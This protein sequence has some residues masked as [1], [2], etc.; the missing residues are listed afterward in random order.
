MINKN[1][2]GFFVVLSLRNFGPNRYNSIAIQNFPNFLESEI[3]EFQQKVSV[4]IG[5]FSPTCTPTSYY[6][7]VL[8]YEKSQQLSCYHNVES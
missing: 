8:V 5:I 7:V 6:Y 1:M 3:F 4:Q 2:H